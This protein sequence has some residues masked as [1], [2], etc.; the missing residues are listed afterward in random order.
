[1]LLLLSRHAGA[2]AGAATAL[3][4]QLQN[5]SLD[6]CAVQQLHSMMLTQLTSLTS[7][8]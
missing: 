2:A 8:E 4:L 1:L 7:P 6:F 5:L 3:L